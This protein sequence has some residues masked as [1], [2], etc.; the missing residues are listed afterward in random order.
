MTEEWR[1]IAG[2]EGLY[3]VSNRG[4]VMR[5]TRDDF[6]PRQGRRTKRMEGGGVMIYDIVLER[7]MTKQMFIEADSKKEALRKAD[8]IDPDDIEDWDNDWTE[9][10]EK[11]VMEF[12]D[13]K[14]AR[15]FYS[16]GDDIPAYRVI[17]GQL[18]EIEED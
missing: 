12:P 4:E 8:Q 5:M 16:N 1:D 13:L 6:F 2:Y 7:T 11:N 3:K 14:E 17:A 15:D 18:F 9:P 10:D